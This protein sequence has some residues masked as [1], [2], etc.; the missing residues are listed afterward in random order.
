MLVFFDLISKVYIIH[1]TFIEKLNLVVQPTNVNTLKID[2]T[3][4]EI[5]EIIVVVFLIID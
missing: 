2:G 5:Y 4:L 1:L 3:T